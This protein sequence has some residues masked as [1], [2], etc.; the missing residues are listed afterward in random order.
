[1]NVIS[2]HGSPSSGFPPPANETY[3]ANSLTGLFSSYKSVQKEGTLYL[4]HFQASGAH[5]KGSPIAEA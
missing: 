3:F 4:P 2:E 5:D 1:M